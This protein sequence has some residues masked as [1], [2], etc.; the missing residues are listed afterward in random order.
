M[1]KQNGHMKKC[2]KSTTKSVNLHNNNPHSVRHLHHCSFWHF[3]ERCLMPCHVRSTLPNVGAN[4]G[5]A[6]SIKNESTDV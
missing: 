2:N 6:A 1:A 5:F 3:R 4:R